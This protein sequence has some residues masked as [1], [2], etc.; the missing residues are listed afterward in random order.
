MPN[1]RFT[2]YFASSRRGL[3]AGLARLVKDVGAGRR[4]GAGRARGCA[5]ALARV[6]CAGQSR[7]LADGDRQAPRV[8][9]SFGATNVGSASKTRSHTSSKPRAE[10][11][12]KDLDAALDDDVGDDLLRLVFTS[13]HP[14]LSTEA[15]V[16]LTLRLLGGLT[17]EE[18]ARALPGVRAH[19]RAA[20]RARQAPTGRFPSAFRSACAVRSSRYAWPRFWRSCT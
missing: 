16:A 1:A 18:I 2:P 4:V 10:F 13:C 19:D 14:I 7:S 8:S 6:G 12:A 17:T 9:T 5:R 15:R 20:H 3:I 11:S